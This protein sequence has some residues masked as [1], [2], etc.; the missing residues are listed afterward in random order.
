M[1][2]HPIQ[3]INATFFE[4]IY[5]SKFILGLVWQQELQHRSS[6]H[7]SH[8]VVTGQLSRHA[9]SSTEMLQGGVAV[10]ALL[11]EKQASTPLQDTSAHSL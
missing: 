3:T 1:L 9:F 10:N 2:F 11:Q 4:S 6:A 8:I 7:H 5:I